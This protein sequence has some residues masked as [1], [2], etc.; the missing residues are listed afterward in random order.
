MRLSDDDAQVRLKTYRSICILTFSHHFILT[1][2]LAGYERL[3]LAGRGL[4]APM[5]SKTKQRSDER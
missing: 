2:F 3:F 1:L 4:M 5:I